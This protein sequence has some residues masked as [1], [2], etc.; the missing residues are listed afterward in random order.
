MGALKVICMCDPN[1]SCIFM[2]I[3]ILT[4]QL[5]CFRFYAVAQVYQTVADDPILGQEEP[6][7][8][9]RGKT[10]EDVVECLDKSLKVKKD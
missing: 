10:V 1:T 9:Q 2:V 3:M 5:L 8:R 6:D 7:D 4:S